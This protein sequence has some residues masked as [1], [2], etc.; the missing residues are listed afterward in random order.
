[1]YK[2]QLQSENNH[3][4]KI[5][6]LEDARPLAYSQVLERWQGD[7]AFRDF[8]LSL[9]EKA[10]FDSY[11]W[12]TPPVTTGNMGRAFEFVLVDSPYLPQTA[13]PTAFK[14]HF[15][16]V[17]PE[18]E[19]AIF[20]NLG[21][22]ALLIAPTPQ[23]SWHAYAHLASFVRGAPRRQVHALW[24]AVGES[25]QKHIGGKP[26]WLNTAGGG[27]PWLHVRLDSRPKYYRYRP[28]KNLAHL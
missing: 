21:H 15:R 12:E 13:D 24:I 5:K 18:R 3:I 7:A 25:M 17:Q 23:D 14:E 6:L 19:V 8:F 9:L 28:Y 16:A 26:I 20:P 1:M 22:D 10:P 11:Q 2:T 27:V 4:Q